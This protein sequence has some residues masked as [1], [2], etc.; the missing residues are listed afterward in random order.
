MVPPTLGF[1]SCCSGTLKSFMRELVLGG[2]QPV[3]KQRWPGNALATLPT[4]G[5]QQSSKLLHLNSS[6]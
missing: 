3:E 1:R 2:S 6:S 4:A 5:G